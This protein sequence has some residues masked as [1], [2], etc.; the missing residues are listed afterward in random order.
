MAS[1]GGTPD[2]RSDGVEGASA[3]V[4]TV[5]PYHEPDGSFSGWGAGGIAGGGRGWEPEQYTAQQSAENAS[6]RPDSRAH[7]GFAARAGGGS[8]SASEG[9][10]N[11]DG[12]LREWGRA[13]LTGFQ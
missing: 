4:G 12:T 13:A 7:C 2:G 3:G 9:S 1:R 6:A 5:G 11:G 8:G 10:Q